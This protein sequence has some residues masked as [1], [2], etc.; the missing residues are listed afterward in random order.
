MKFTKMNGAGNDF[1]ILDAIKENIDI[2]QNSHFASTLCTRHLSIGADGM[3]VVVPSDK[4][5]F[6]MMFYN[7]D[8][9][10]G[11]MCG[12]G[13]RCICRYGYETGLSGEKQ[14]IETTAGIVTG[15]RID[16]INYRI[17]LNDATTV[18]I[19]D[20]IEIDGKEYVVSYVE[21]GNPGLPHGVVSYAQL[22]EQIG[23][24]GARLIDLPGEEMETLKKLAIK[25]R[26][27][28]Y[29]PKGANINFYEVIGDN[30][31][32]LL[33]YERGV[34]DYT[35]ACG[36]GTGSTVLVLNKLGLVP[37]KGSKINEKGGVLYVDLD[38]GIYLTG[39]TNIV[40]EGTVRD[41]TL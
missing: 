40:A 36:T 12:N 34:E 13:A 10:V 1:I 21:L 2:E 8:G 41:E 37:E 29:F 6:R 39:P 4:A 30:E 19:E 27:H 33:T 28:S 20:K 25:M 7:S 22:R 18:K 23:G 35:F 14:V 24:S 26:Y 16:K 9:T 11:E 15:E 31:I 38:D 3:M 32:D 17:R 5:D